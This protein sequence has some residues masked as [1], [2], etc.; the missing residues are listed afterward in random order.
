M[1]DTSIKL[2]NAKDSLHILRTERLVDI[3]K[4]KNEDVLRNMKEI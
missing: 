4:T 2:K 3:M 1:L